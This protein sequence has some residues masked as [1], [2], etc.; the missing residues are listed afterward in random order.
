MREGADDSYRHPIADMEVEGKEIQSR[1]GSN[2]A[3][4]AWGL[5]ISVSGKSSTPNLAKKTTQP[6]LQNI[7]VIRCDE[8]YLGIPHRH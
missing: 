5:S 8:G 1:A 2:I 4:S 7:K 6:E 3:M